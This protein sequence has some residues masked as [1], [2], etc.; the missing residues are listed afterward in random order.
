MGR[1]GQERCDGPAKMT[2]HGMARQTQ[3]TGYLAPVHA[4]TLAEKKYLPRQQRQSQKRARHRG[5]AFITF[6]GPLVENRIASLDGS[7][8]CRGPDRLPAIVKRPICPRCD[9]GERDLPCRRRLIA[10]EA[11]DH[12]SRFLFGVT[13][14]EH[15]GN[16]ILRGNVQPAN[17][18]VGH[19]SLLDKMEEPRELSSLPAHLSLAPSLLFPAS[20]AVRRRS[21]CPP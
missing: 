5:L 4:T 7:A 1:G 2:A 3:K 15:A 8:R 6:Q 10:K 18:I 9:A 17:R 14:R 12:R 11:C 16:E 19:R 13:R 21:G 20:W